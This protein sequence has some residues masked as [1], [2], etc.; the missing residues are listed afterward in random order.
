VQ[1][2]VGVK[3]FYD[4]LEYFWERK[5]KKEEF[6][7]YWNKFIKQKDEEDPLKWVINN[8][9]MDVFKDTMAFH[10]HRL[11]TMQ[12][13][14]LYYPKFIKSKDADIYGWIV[15]NVPEDGDK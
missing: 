14:D 6:D 13:I 10:L 7:F 11:P 15:T 8:V 5:P 3:D 2:P 12:E 9:P 4:E 1:K